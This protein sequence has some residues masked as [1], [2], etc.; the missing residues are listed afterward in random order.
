MVCPYGLV[1][2][3]GLGVEQLLIGDWLLLLITLRQQFQY[4]K[5]RPV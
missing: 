2:L 4:V 3:A 1:E 5:Q